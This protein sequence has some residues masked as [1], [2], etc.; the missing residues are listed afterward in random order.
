[1]NVQ[2][3]KKKVEQK[4]AVKLRIEQTAVTNEKEKERQSD[5]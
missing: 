5:I 2:W 1:L 3:K 4:E